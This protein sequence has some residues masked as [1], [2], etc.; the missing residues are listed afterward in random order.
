VGLAEISMADCRHR[1]GHFGV[2][3]R[4]RNHQLQDSAAVRH[5]TSTAQRDVDVNG[6]HEQG[7]DGLVQ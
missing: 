7:V 1:C 5:I 3:P 6:V 2:L 4:L